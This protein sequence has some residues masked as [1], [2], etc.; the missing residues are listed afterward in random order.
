MG[1]FVVLLF[2]F[3]VV[4]ADLRSGQHGGAIFIA[5][6][7]VCYWICIW[8]ELQRQVRIYTDNVIPKI[9]KSEFNHG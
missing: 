3:L 7:L 9:S 5:T 2:Q 4:V 6:G 1:F 8:M